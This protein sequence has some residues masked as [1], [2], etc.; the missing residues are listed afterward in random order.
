MN[1]NQENFDSFISSEERVIVDFHAS[2]CGPCKAMTPLV[3]QLDDEFPNR[4]G[5][6]DVDECP[7]VAARFG[8]K[9]IPTVLVF[10]SGAMVERKIG[11]L[12]KDLMAGLLS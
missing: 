7:D 8:I 2:W 10:Q 5:K 4:V 1:L 9:S 11:M 12:S 6:V 3:E